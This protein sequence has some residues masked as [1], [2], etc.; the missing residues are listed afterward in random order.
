MGDEADEAGGGDSPL[1]ADVVAD[2]AEEVGV[3]E[4]G[5]RWM[6]WVEVGVAALGFAA[7]STG[8]GLVV[9]SL[10]LAT[11]ARTGSA[12]LATGALAVEFFARFAVSM[13]AAAA[14]KEHGRK[15]VILGAALLGVLGGLLAFADY[16]A[17]T[18]VLYFVGIALIG[19]A[20]CVAQQ[21][22]FVA[23]EAVAPKYKPRALSLTVAGGTI[24]AFVGPELAPAS[25]RLLPID[26]AGS[27]LIMACCY[28]C[29]FVFTLGL[30][31][32]DGPRESSW[33]GVEATTGCCGQREVDAEEKDPEEGPDDEP[34]DKEVGE[35]REEGWRDVLRML[36]EFPEVRKGVGAVTVAWT[37]MFLVMSAAPLAIVGDA[38]GGHTFE[39]SSRALQIHLILMFLPGLLG[40]GD[41]VR[42][43][44]HD[45]VI[46]AGLALYALCS[47]FTYMA[48]PMPTGAVPLWVFMT[49]LAILG[50]AW[51]LIFVAGSAL[52][53]PREGGFTLPKSKIVQGFAEACTFG[54]VAIVAASSGAILSAAGWRGLNLCILPI[55]FGLLVYLAHD[56]ISRS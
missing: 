26:F 3:V 35:Q 24:A 17:H 36:G 34:L 47:V 52:M 49:I 14:A 4:D 56:R 41:L 38:D 6:D 8:F 43:F 10:A 33:V 11:Q 55:T 39:E 51:N 37:C 18:Y 12:A 16:Y 13:P 45:A 31:T 22:R 5:D 19:V 53:T 29:L 15:V 30:T 46:C 32:V 25:R 1:D 21:L 54:L 50:L 40:T 23:A 42:I 48:T 7:A 2:V 9:A 44:G 20:N 27:F 28:L